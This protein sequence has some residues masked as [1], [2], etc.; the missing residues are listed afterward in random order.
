MSWVYKGST[1]LS[2]SRDTTCPQRISRGLLKL[3][4]GGSDAVHIKEFDF[5]KG[6]FVDDQPFYLP[7]AKTRISY[8]SRNVLLV[9]TD[10]GPG[11]LT[12]SGYPRTVREWVR[13][14]DFQNDSTLVF[15][16]ESTDVSVG[17]YIADERIWG[18]GIYEVQYRSMTFYT[19][20]YRI[21]KVQFEHLLA[22]DDP[23]REGIPDPPDFVLVDIQEDAS[24]NF[25]GTMLII[26]LRSDWEVG[27]KTYRKGSQLITDADTFIAQG[28]EKSEFTLLFEPTESNSYEYYTLTKNYL[29]LSTTDYVKS[30]LEFYKITQSGLEKVGKPTEPQIRDCS[31]SPVDPYG[32]SDE[33]WFTTSDYITPTTLSLANA[34]LVEKEG[35]GDV[36]FVTEGLKSLPVQY[37]ASDLAME[38]RVAKSADGTEVPYFIVYSKN[39]TLDGN[40]PTLLYGYGGFEVSLG[41]HYIATAGLAWLERGGVY[42]RYRVSPFSYVYSNISLLVE[43]NIRG[44]GEFGP[45][46]HQSALKSNRCKSYEDFIAV[47]EHLIGSGICTAQTLAA[48][49]GS[50]VRIY[51]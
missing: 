3:S 38:Q 5:V 29:I 46:W 45:F 40:N 22:P 31:A 37:N 32:G 42:G 36:S 26:S 35:A 51:V 24:I 49:G 7:E 17:M 21:R 2:R 43:A 6:D 39:M 30:K 44:G 8:K 34:Q 47:A 19:T 4:R 11:S 41:P 15:E 18:G 25:V 10:C 33:F 23:N 13:G 28:A 12:D 50:N 16:G 1:K 9:G 20:Q 48:R 27:G 14:T